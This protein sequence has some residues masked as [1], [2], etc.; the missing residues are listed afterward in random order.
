MPA[1]KYIEN[2]VQLLRAQYLETPN[3]LLTPGEAADLVE[4]DRQTAVAALQALEDLWFLGTHDRGLFL[5]G[6]GADQHV[7][8][9]VPRHRPMAV[10]H[11]S[12]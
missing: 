4:L 12:A 2:A 7:D 9:L 3:L 6:L 8:A 5:S 1:S 11:L 10:T